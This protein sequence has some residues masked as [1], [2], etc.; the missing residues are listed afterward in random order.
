MEVLK[1]EKDAKSNARQLA[2]IV[3]KNTILNSTKE[4]YLEDVWYK[5]TEEQRDM[6]KNYSLEALHSK[7]KGVIRA[8]ASALTSICIQEIPHGRWLNVLNILCSNTIDADFVTR[9]ASLLSLGYI[10]EELRTNE[11]KKEQA[12]YIISAFLDSLEKN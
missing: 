4:E 6:L 11:L 1:D 7:D 9:Y 8:A 2:G 12:D 3:F 5:M 10:C